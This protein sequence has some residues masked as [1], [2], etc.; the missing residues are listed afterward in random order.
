MYSLL[1]EENDHKKEVAIQKSLQIGRVSEGVCS[2]FSAAFSGQTP[3]SHDHFHMARD[4]QGFCSILFK[5]FFSC[6]IR[7]LFS[8]LLKASFPSYSRPLFHPIPRLFSVLFEASFPSY[9]KPFLFYSKPLFRPIRRNFSVLFE[10]SLCPIQ[11]LYPSYL[12]PLFHTIQYLFHL[13]QHRF[14]VLFEASF[15]S[16]SKP[17]VHPT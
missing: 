10:A 15:L 6:P 9:S 14:S 8:V 11:S 1:L 16:Y 4:L 5:A 3:I 7:R 13:I 17:P 12:K 2:A